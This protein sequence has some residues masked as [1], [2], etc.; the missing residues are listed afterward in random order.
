MEHSS[1]SPI[2]IISC[3]GSCL[4]KRTLFLLIYF[5]CACACIYIYIYINLLTNVITYLRTY[6]LTYLL[7]H[8][9]EQC[10][11]LE[12]NLFSA[13]QEIPHNLWNPKVHYRIHKC[14]PPVPIL[15]QLDP[16][17]NP[18]SHF[19]KIHLVLPSLLRLG[20]PSG[21][22]HSSF[23]TKIMYTPLLPPHSLHSPPIP[24][25]ILS[26]EQY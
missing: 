12:A 25:S 3:Y 23:P 11:S 14:P 18:T 9:M 6:L 4:K 17:N 16:V 10:P 8:S 19:L 13:S 26:P 5:V 20:L 7:T 15:S 22:F 1:R 2:T 24:F 21:L